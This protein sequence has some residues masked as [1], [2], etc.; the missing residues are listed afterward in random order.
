MNVASTLLLWRIFGSGC[1]GEEK[2]RGGQA[3]ARETREAQ[4]LIEAVQA[5]ERAALGKQERHRT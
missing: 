2:T 4:K 3:E 5:V 1:V